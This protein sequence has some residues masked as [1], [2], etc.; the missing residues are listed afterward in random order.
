M[1][2]G[3]GRTFALRNLGACVTD[4]RA[5]ARRAR[6]AKTVDRMR[7]RAGI[8]EDELAERSQIGRAELAE[9]LGGEIEARVDTIYLLAGAL[10]VDPGDLLEGVTW[11]PGPRGGGRYEVE[12]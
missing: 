3:G 1:R 8:S 12:D 9:I 11:V 4:S 7:R 2:S 10:K 5:A 6:F